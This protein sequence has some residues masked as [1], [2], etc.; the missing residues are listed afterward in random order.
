MGKKSNGTGRVKGGR[1]CEG[2][3]QEYYGRRQPRVKI[4]NMPYRSLLLLKPPEIHPY[5]LIKGVKQCTL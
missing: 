1:G 5:A 4:L 2:K 3:K